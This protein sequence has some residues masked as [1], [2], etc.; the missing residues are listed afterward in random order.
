MKFLLRSIVCLICLEISAQTP[1]PVDL[2]WN[3][4]ANAGN[5]WRT[6][7]NSMLSSKADHERLKKFEREC[8]RFFRVAREAQF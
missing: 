1:D 3:D 4:L 6:Q 5:A 7:H 8:K 2:A